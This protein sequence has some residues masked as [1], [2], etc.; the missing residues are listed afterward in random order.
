MR[1]TRTGILTGEADNIPPDGEAYKIVM[2]QLDNQEKALTAMF[3]GTEIKSSVMSKIIEIVPERKNIDKQVVA[4]F[5]VKLGVVAADDLSGA[6]IYLSLKSLEPLEEIVLTEKEAKA[7]EDKYSKGVV[8][9]IPAKADLKVSYKGKEYV[10]TEFDVVQFGSKEVLTNRM[11]ENNKKPIKVI[12]Y[13]NLGAI[14][15]IIE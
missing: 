6:P 11:F 1:E 14:K 7:W 2:K 3:M 4:R 13:P 9:N 5:S 15:Q 12:F 10:N 8:F